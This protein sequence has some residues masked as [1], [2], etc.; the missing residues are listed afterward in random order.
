MEH[1]AMKRKT[2]RFQHINP[3]L[4]RDKNVYYP[5]YHSRNQLIGAEF[6]RLLKLA[7]ISLRELIK[8]SENDNYTRP[9]SNM[10]DLPCLHLDAPSAPVSAG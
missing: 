10:I 8:T 1:F 3:Y 9:L 5:F 2:S 6:I 7:D 4:N